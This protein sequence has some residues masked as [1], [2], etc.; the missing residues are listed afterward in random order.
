MLRLIYLFNRWL[1]GDQELYLSQKCELHVGRRGR[2]LSTNFLVAP[3]SDNIRM[4]NTD[5]AMGG[6]SSRQIDDV[7]LPFPRKLDM[8]LHTNFLLTYN[9]YVV[10]LRD[11]LY[12]V[13]YP[14]FYEKYFQLSSAEIFTQNAKR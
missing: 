4:M 1:H 5:A 3:D 12:E 13:S 9:L 7:F 8:T 6:F 2:P 11:N 10:S 14:V